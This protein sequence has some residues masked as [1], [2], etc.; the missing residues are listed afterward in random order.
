[1]NRTT[2]TSQNP[3]PKAYYVRSNAVP[4]TRVA[5]I[6]K[7]AVKA[8]ITKAQAEAAYDTLLAIAYAGA[9]K[10]GGITLPGLFKLS[11]GKRAACT[12]VNPKTKEKITIPAAPVVKI[13][14]LKVLNDSVITK[15]KSRNEQ[16]QLHGEGGEG[17]VSCDATSIIH[18]TNQGEPTWESPH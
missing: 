16:R 18:P 13:K 5:I 3:T 4:T 12:G 9:K 8:G 11:I 1:M 17:G 14:V 2:E 6:A 15:R 7:I 10:T